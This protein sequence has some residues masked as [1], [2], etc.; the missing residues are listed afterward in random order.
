MG[1]M[2][3]NK[4][5]FKVYLNGD[6]TFLLWLVIA[7]VIL[8]ITGEYSA[9]IIMFTATLKMF[10]RFGSKNLKMLISLGCTRKKYY[11]NIIK[12]SLI[13]SS[14]LSI[15]CTILNFLGE[16]TNNS[17]H[18]LIIFL[19]Y[20]MFYILFSSIEIFVEVLSISQY[21][22]ILFGG[23]FFYAILYLR[24]I[25]FGPIIFGDTDWLLKNFIPYFWG[26]LD[27]ICF[28]MCMS[29]VALK[30]TEI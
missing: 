15:V 3:V 11:I 9:K 7:A 18:I 22:A 27:A 2:T 26:S 5:I 25:I 30:T 19:F 4:N 17:R 6:K 28:N 23:V 13:N 20:F 14:V 8:P 12:A 10:D 24:F 21:A 16:R 29:T 1:G